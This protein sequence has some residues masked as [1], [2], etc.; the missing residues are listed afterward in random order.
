MYSKV[1]SHC[2]TS[3]HLP[4]TTMFVTSWRAICQRPVLLSHCRRSYA[5]SSTQEARALSQKQV[6]EEEAEFDKAIQKQKDRP[7]LREGSKTAPVDKKDN[8]EVKSISGKLLTMP[9]RLLKLVIPLGPNITRAGKDGD[10][11]AVIEPLAL[12]VHPRQPISYLERLIQSELPM[13]EGT[14]I[15]SV[16]FLAQEHD[17]EQPNKFV[18]WSSS[19][20]IGDF[21]RDAA[22]SKQFLVSVND[23][24]EDEAIVVKVPSFHDRTHYLRLRLSSIKRRLRTMA[25]VKQEC[26]IAAHR[27]GQRVALAGFGVLSGWWYVVY[28]LT[29]QSPYGWETM[30]PVTYLVSLSA[31]MV[32][33]LWFLYHN[34]EVSYRAALHLTISRRQSKL[35]KERG[36]DLER[37]E[38]L[39]EEASALRREISKVAEEYGEEWEEGDEDEALKKALEEGEKKLRE[40]EKRDED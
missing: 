6:D 17:S 20:E 33:Y 38:R 26:D 1:H 28:R 15:P 5:R 31:V 35:Y 27:G 36:F 34:R 12:L 40:K 8:E 14:K 32:G 21:I 30:E 2:L 7:W 24:P 10:P 25:T 37:W 3:F 4:S 11:N 22:R 16:S 29:F 23:A 39:V 18:R 9:S 13:S 19:T